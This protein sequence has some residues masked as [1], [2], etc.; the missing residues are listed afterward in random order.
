MKAKVLGLGVR[1]EGRCV[2][3][4]RLTGTAPYQLRETV[5]LR[6]TDGKYRVAHPGCI[7][8]WVRHKVSRGPV[9]EG[10]PEEVEVK[11]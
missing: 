4:G 11:F 6:L 10:A 5:L 9:L 3:C 7:G 8:G 1:Y 2:V